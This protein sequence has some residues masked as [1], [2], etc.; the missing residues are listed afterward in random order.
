MSSGD[1]SEQV[2]PGNGTMNLQGIF[3]FILALLACYAGTAMLMIL[4]GWLV[5]SPDAQESQR[6]RL[7]YWAVVA[8]LLLPLELLVAAWEHLAP[9]SGDAQLA[10]ISVLFAAMPLQ[11]GILVF[12]IAN[13]REIGAMG[14]RSWLIVLLLAA[15]L[16]MLALFNPVFSLGL[17][18]VM[19]LLALLWQIDGWALDWLSVAVLL[20]LLLQKIIQPDQPLS[21]ALNALDVAPP[22]GQAA[23]I[24]LAILMLLPYLLPA[25]LVYRSLKPTGREQRIRGGLRL[26]LAAA[27]LLIITYDVGET[28]FWA[29]AQ[30]RFAEDNFPFQVVLPLVFGLLLALLL[31][32]WRRLA[33]ALYG[34]LVPAVLITAFVLGWNISNTAV[35]EGRARRINAALG[36]Y[37]QQNGRYPDR[38]AQL[39]PGYLLFNLPPAGNDLDRSWCY[40]SG[41]DA[42]R[43]GYIAVN[44][45]VPYR[46]PDV[47]VRILQHVGS[48]PNTAWDCDTKAQ[49]VKAIYAA[50][51]H[52]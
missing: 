17:L 35:T 47:S 20:G 11:A 52:P 7:F 28:A 45:V 42:F 14:R 44:F 9:G 21:A 13:W 46:M 8:A 27:L 48:F 51:Y 18:A 24:A 50:R 2:F 3:P 37:Y 40:Q 49:A 36:S 32:G 31:P 19:V 26:G 30:S 25:L 29:S 5:A 33:G 10:L 22:I 34:L 38:L 16:V 41:P 4:E 6:R 23:N 39:T 43:L 1:I 15:P 12:S